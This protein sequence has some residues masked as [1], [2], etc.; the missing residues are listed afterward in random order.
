MSTETPGEGATKFG[1]GWDFQDTTFGPHQF[2][3]T[4]NIPASISLWSFPQGRPA[5]AFPV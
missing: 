3:S 5:Q 4:V 2:A 1:A